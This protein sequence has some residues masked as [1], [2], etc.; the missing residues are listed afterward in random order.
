MLLRMHNPLT[1]VE[2]P[3]LFEFILNLNDLH[4]NTV[5]LRQYCSH[6]ILVTVLGSTLVSFPIKLAPGILSY[7]QNLL[8]V[9]P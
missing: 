7:I 2:G 6:S 4:A 9:L 8:Q 3:Y 1:F 5:S